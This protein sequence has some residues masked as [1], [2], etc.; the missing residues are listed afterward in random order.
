MC[1]L[2]ASSQP[3]RSTSGKGIAKMLGVDRW[4]MK[5]GLERQ[6]LLD[7][8]NDAFGLRYKCVRH[9]DCLSNK[10]RNLVINWWGNETTISLDMKD[11]AKRH[12]GVKLYETH[13]KHYLQISHVSASS[14][15]LFIV[16][17]EPH[18]VYS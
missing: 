7:T 4:N 12:I 9:L 17:I 8:E 15:S 13:P 10:V 5:R 11:V 2:V 1:T 16:S 18:H 14:F 6:I 3:M